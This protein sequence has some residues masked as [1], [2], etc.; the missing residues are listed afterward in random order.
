[1]KISRVGVDLAKSVF[2][3]HGSDAHGKAVWKRKLSRRKWVESLCNTAPVGCEVGMEACASAHHWARLL[4]Q[5]GYQVKLIPP[6]FVTPYVKSNKWERTNKRN[7]TFENADKQRILCDFFQSRS[8]P[9]TSDA[10]TRR[11]P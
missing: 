2:Q 7:E 3:L 10:N 4:T 9:P 8:C 6:Q 5:H 1:M 11:C